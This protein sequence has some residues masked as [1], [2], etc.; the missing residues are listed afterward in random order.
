VEDTGI[1][2]PAEYHDKIFQHF[3]QADGSTTRQYGGTGLGLTICKRLLEL[4]DGS[5]HVESLPG[6]GSKFWIHVPLEKSQLEYSHSSNMA[7]LIGIRALVVDDNQTN[8]EIL[9]IQ[10]Q[11]WQINV[12]CANGAEQSLMFMNKALENNEPFHLAI[13]DMHM[14]KM[15]GLQLADKIYAHLGMRKTRM[16]MLTSTHSDASQLEKQSIGILRCVNKP[17][18]QKELFEIICDVMG[19]DLAKSATE[20][21]IEQAPPAQLT[22][23]IK[24]RILVAEDNPVNQEVAKAMLNKLGMETIIA[25]DGKQA[26]EL[27]YSNP[28]DII[29]MDCQMPVMD[30]FEATS[31]IRKQ[32]G[33]IPIIALTANATEDDRTHCLNAGMNDFLSK[34]YSIDQLQ[35]KITDWLSKEKSNPL[36]AVKLGAIDMKHDANIMPVLNPTRL[37]QIR[38]LDSSGEDSLLNKILQAFLESAESNIRHL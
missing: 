15:N 37:N 28:Y 30:G 32:Y 31:E 6:Q 27:V 10:L 21:V 24:G 17:I 8:R 33:N 2:I 14:P 5:I 35:Q 29:L 26:V 11:N 12:V 22:A 34:P 36:N 18:R 25:N 3:S 13:L 1:G 19:R 9:K 4:M 38:E 7:D 23:G 20:D 16:M